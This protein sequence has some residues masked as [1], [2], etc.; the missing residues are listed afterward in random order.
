MIDKRKPNCQSLGLEKP[1]GN[2]L[3][4]A[5]KSLLAT[6]RF[7]KNPRWLWLAMFLACYRSLSLSLWG[8]EVSCI[9]ENLAN[10]TAYS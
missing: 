6:T 7:R 9:A 10:T 8:T 2:G 3:Q 1:G 5:E 4:S